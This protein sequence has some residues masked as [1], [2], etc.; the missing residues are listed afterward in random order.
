MKPEIW[1]NSKTGKD[2]SINE[3]IDEYLNNPQV[4]EKMELA[5]SLEKKKNDDRQTKLQ[6]N[7]NSFLSRKRELI[8]SF[9]D[10]IHE[11][12]DILKIDLDLR[13]YALELY[14][15]KKKYSK[16]EL[17]LNFDDLINKPSDILKI[18]SK[19]RPYA[20]ELYKKRKEKLSQELSKFYVAIWDYIEFKYEE[21][22]LNKEDLTN[23]ILSFDDSLL[24]KKSKWE[25]EFRVDKYWE[26]YQKILKYKNLNSKIDTI[27]ALII[28]PDNIKKINLDK[29]EITYTPYSINLT[30]LDDHDAFQAF[31]EKDKDTLDVDH[32]KSSG[33]S[34]FKDET[35][36]TVVSAKIDFP[37]E[38][39]RI[40]VHEQ[41]HLKDYYFSYSYGV[42]KEGIAYSLDCA[43]AEI[44]AF[45]IEGLKLDKI[46]DFLEYNYISFYEKL[47]NNDVI[48]YKKILNEAFLVLQKMQDS[49]MSP[50]KI[51]DLFIRVDINKWNKEYKRLI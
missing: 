34:C 28:N 9:D 23:Y 2:K 39:D 22:T 25:V 42:F 18:D 20:I 1:I 48:L 40:F 4:V 5:E 41:Q 49:G 12:A 26:C 16:D 3:G 35:P 31:L 17:A 19:L 37:E 50:D 46:K 47:S 27:S 10:L 32:S 44:F 8:L 13:S 7:Y 30:I 11:E 38:S 15:K 6:E 36:V 45:L 24:D 29:I 51:I 33:A 43:K 21:N 14:K